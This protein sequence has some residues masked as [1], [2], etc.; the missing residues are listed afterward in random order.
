MVIVS[1][2]VVSLKKSELNFGFLRT[3]CVQN[4]I[5]FAHTPF[6]AQGRSLLKMG[7]NLAHTPFLAQGRSLLKM[8]NIGPLFRLAPIQPSLFQKHAWF[9]F[10]Q[11]MLKIAA[12]TLRTS[13]DK[14]GW[15]LCVTGFLTT[16][17]HDKPY[18]SVIHLWI[19]N[20]V[21]NFAKLSPYTTLVGREK[22][23]DAADSGG[24]LKS[25]MILHEPILRSR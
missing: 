15:L 19:Q 25:E 13:F 7:L 5:K 16:G 21:E 23:E 22:T 10:H 20:G 17:A 8:G 18:H 12:C 6:L 1:I 24:I 9:K 11:I 2:Y 4:W 3:Y 14:D